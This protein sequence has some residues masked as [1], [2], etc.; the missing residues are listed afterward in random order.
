MAHSRV[1]M[2]L[3]AKCIKLNPEAVELDDLGPL[4]AII[5]A[6]KVAFHIV[7]AASHAL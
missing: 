3:A 1:V 6:I 2:L 5:Y 7:F 4:F